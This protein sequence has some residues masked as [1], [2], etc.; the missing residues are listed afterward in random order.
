MNGIIVKLSLRD[1]SGRNRRRQARDF[2][3]DFAP[4]AAPLPCTIRIS[5]VK[6]RNRGVSRLVSVSS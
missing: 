3:L 2:T 6:V 5:C 1:A 4:A